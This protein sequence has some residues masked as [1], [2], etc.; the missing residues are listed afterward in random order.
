MFVN[1]DVQV[2]VLNHRSNIIYSFNCNWSCSSSTSLPI[3][4]IPF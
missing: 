1:E 4:D 3:Y 2:N